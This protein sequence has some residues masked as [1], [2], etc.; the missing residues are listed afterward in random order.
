MFFHPIFTKVSTF[1]PGIPDKEDFGSLTELGKSDKNILTKSLH[2][3]N[4]A[5][6]HI[7]IRVGNPASGLLSWATKNEPPKVPG[8]A[9]D[10]FQQPKHSYEYKD[11]SGK[12][13][14][15]YGAGYVHPAKQYPIL[16]DALSDNHLDFAIDMGGGISRY[17]L[18]RSK[19]ED[20]LWHLINISPNPKLP[21]KLKYKTINEE[22]AKKLI[23]FVGKTIESVQPKIDGAL[24]MV[25]IRKGKLE[26]FSHR[27]SK[28]TGR[29]IL[30]TER[31]FS[32]IPKIE[33]LDPELNDT[34]LLTEIYAVQKGPDGKERV[35]RP[36]ELS[37][38]LNSKFYKTIEDAK[39]QNIEFRFY[40]FD[41]LKLVKNKED[42]YPEWYNQPY[43]GRVE[44]INKVLKFLPKSFHG[45][46]EAK[47]S[48]TAAQLLETIRKRM[49]PLTQ[50][51]VVFFPKSGVPY[52]YKLTSEKD[53]YIVG[54]EPGE[55]K[56]SGS[57]VGA[58]LY[59]DKPDGKPIG[60]IGT[61]IPDSLRKEFFENPDE[62]I[63]RKIRVGYL[64]ELGSG[65]LRN[66]VFKGLA[67]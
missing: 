54:F 40:V 64:E 6:P 31:L 27:I 44:Y 50:E 51:G 26:V 9:I 15:G 29:P 47:D 16:I 32:G 13:E 14:S 4:K 25:V 48:Q 55:G 33:N 62:Y 66:P 53:F 8:A 39:K 56:Y 17:K 23:S 12:I 30:H 41:A 65:K 35:L 21:P 59:S 58:I 18:I 45:P 36:E 10:L 63:G 42:D 61:G 24:G 46:I 5:G 28:V 67:E 60:K 1:A 3:A 19:K 7:D 52:K 20:K 38:L 2:E 11:F 34:V 49:H 43:S 37:G 57:G 22:A